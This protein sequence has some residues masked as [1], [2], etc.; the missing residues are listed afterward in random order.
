MPALKAKSSSSLAI[1][2]C[3]GKNDFRFQFHLLKLSLAE[4]TVTTLFQH[5][6]YINHVQFS[7][8]VTMS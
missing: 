8:N 7:N 4:T 5:K 6:N 1:I 3:T 2:Q